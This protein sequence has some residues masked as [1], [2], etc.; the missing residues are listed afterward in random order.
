MSADSTWPM[1]LYRGYKLR[2]LRL[3]RR[4]SDRRPN[5][6]GFKRKDFVLAGLAVVLLAAPLMMGERSAPSS[7][8]AR[9]Q[10]PDPLIPVNF[11]ALEPVPDG[12]APA[13]VSLAKVE[14]LQ[15]VG[16]GLLWIARVVDEKGEPLGGEVVEWA[17][18]PR[19]VGRIGSVAQG[20]GGLSVDST[21]QR[22]EPR[23]AR[24]RTARARYTLR[25]SADTA[26]VAEP[27]VIEL[28][29]CWCLVHSDSPGD[30]VMAAAAPRIAALEDRES[31]A[32]VHWHCAKA[33]FPG[34]L[35]APAGAGV[36]L[37]TRVVDD[38]SGLPLAGYRVRYQT[39]E[40][41]GAA[42]ANGE[43]AIEVISDSAGYAVARTDPLAGGQERW[44]LDAR[45]LAERTNGAAAP[46]V[47]AEAPITIARAPVSPQIVVTGPTILP[48][49]EWATL[50]VETRGMEGYQGERPELVAIM[51]EGL[52][53]DPPAVRGETVVPRATDPLA[54][55]AAVA[56]RSASPGKRAVR[57]ELRAGG[58]VL[59]SQRWEGEF[60][61][62]R[63]TIEKRLPR[64]WPLG[65]SG[66][67]QLVI[68]NEGPVAARDVE[69]A[70]EVPMGLRIDAADALRRPDELRWN[71][72]D[73]A[74]GTKKT[75]AVRA[76]P[77]QPIHL[78]SLRTSARTRCDTEGVAHANF[79]VE[80]LAALEMI[81]VDRR[82]PVPLGE[83]IEYDLTLLNRGSGRAEFV[84]FEVATPNNLV[85]EEA[86]GSL[87]ARVRDGVLM[88]GPAAEL[89]AGDQLGVTLK[90][91]ALREGE[92]RLSVRLWH[93]STGKE[94]LERQESTTIV[95]AGESN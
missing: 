2:S 59:A 65:R 39:R 49:R 53:A 29:E 54:S 84:K 44:V 43:P 80:G 33:I 35:T 3:R 52:E 17:I 72:G 27:L 23:F 60:V 6:W 4:L 67:Y 24:S 32:S 46:V 13:K 50:K 28:G 36:V 69:L 31:T 73:L 25:L 34:E 93:E 82:D 94:G 83:T 91:R 18:D 19:S 51:S 76:T 9:P 16:R 75:I 26:S 42:L 1:G 57:H 90:A 47:L 81:L 63:L 62:P 8:A 15:R 38:Q 58:R 64:P 55:D 37:A 41:A 40:P 66:E 68:A 87:P 48:I 86:K 79:T 56:V 92:A 74:P 7:S 88:L 10:D 61:A 22:L 71:L 70:D 21:G 30:M 77:V 95:E 20:E 89:L 78:V 14:P 11:E 85:W 5:L 12:A 45:L